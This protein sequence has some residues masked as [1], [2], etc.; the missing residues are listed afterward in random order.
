MKNDKKKEIWLD[1]EELRQLLEGGLYWKDI[2]PKLSEE[3]AESIRRQFSLEDEAD[4]NDSAMDEYDQNTGEFDQTNGEYGRTAR[5]SPEEDQA[6]AGPVFAGDSDE[7]NEEIRTILLGDQNSGQDELQ[8][9]FISQAASLEDDFNGIEGISEINDPAE[10]SPNSFSPLADTEAVDDLNKADEAYNAE[11]TA[12]IPKRPTDLGTLEETEV[13]AEE[14]S[15]FSDLNSYI[16]NSKND[17]SADDDDD[18]DFEFEQKSGFG[19]LKLV[20]LVAIV[21]AV[22]FGLWYFFISD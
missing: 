22:T 3:N 14:R 4:I 19:G 7:D 5:K 20:I 18:L 17:P 1:P 6:E 2:E 21:A 13:G 9:L 12:M 11:D 8:R 10:T 16:M 15:R